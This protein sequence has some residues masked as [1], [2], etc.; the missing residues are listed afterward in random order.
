M[1]PASSVRRRRGRVETAVCAA[2]AA[3]RMGGRA[4]PRYAGAESLAREVA[5]ALDVA[6]WNKDPY[7]V[8]QLAPRLESALCLLRLTP[9]S[10]AGGGDLAG[11]LREIRD[12]A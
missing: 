2:I 11:L 5:R 1:L 10:A 3:G 9:A 8:A 7:A 12:G 6:A 4:E